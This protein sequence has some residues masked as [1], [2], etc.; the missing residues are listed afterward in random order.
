M[1]PWA[2][3]S[4]LAH[5]QCDAPRSS[6]AGKRTGDSASEPRP[7]AIGA[8]VEANSDAYG[9][10]VAACRSRLAFADTEDLVQAIGRAAAFAQRFHPG[11]FADG[12]LENPLLRIGARAVVPTPPGSCPRMRSR[13][14]RRRVLHVAS[15]VHSLGGHTRM[16]RQWIASDPASLHLVFLTDQRDAPVPGWLSETV[17]AAGGALIAPGGVRSRIAMA[18]ALRALAADN[19]DVVILHHSGCDPV[20]TLAFASGITAP[21]AAV[22]HAEHQFWLGSGV[23][24]LVI[25]LRRAGLEMCAS[26]RHA[27]A[28]TVLP[29]PL[30]E[31]RTQTSR[32]H[33]RSN[34]AI[35]AARRVLLTVGRG[36]KYRP[37]GS[38]DFVATACRILELE[39]AA[40]LYLV[41][42]TERGLSPY[43]GRA[44]HPRMHLV[45]TIEDPHDFRA[46]ADVYLESFPFGSNTAVLEAAAHALA[47]VPA[48]APLSPLLVAGNDSLDRLLRNPTTE[49]AYVRRV[50]QLLGDPER[51]RNFGS[52]LAD[53]VRRHHVGAGWQRR[54]QQTYA[55]L[56]SLVHRPRELPSVEGCSHS[57]ADVALSLWTAVADGV[58]NRKSPDP[59]AAGDIERHS[60]FVWKEALRYDRARRA[61]WRAL[62]AEPSSTA[63]WRLLVVCALGLPGRRLG[64][65]LRKR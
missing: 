56:E 19:A 33:A 7:R 24:D 21:V 4:S 48:Y 6:R 62:V 52:D 31:G 60:A 49:E 34:L 50:R 1:S 54:L 13:G 45:G 10:L 30:D 12:A 43:L 61:A 20:P 51:A 16:L 42:E 41:G 26:R 47:V 46:A 17:H 58:S 29:I 36:V 59:H 28:S 27:S 40:H 23:V 35:P 55:A 32:E 63:S 65:T 3:P 2:Q 5:G 22:N 53:A 18:G 14:A 11:R 8:F 37:C 64:Q 38:F 9:H 57:S 44:L 39:P 25:N 15:Q